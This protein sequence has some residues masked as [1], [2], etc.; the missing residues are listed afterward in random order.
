MSQLSWRINTTSS[1]HVLQQMS[2]HRGQFKSPSANDLRNTLCLYQRN[3]C[4]Y[5][6]QSIS[7]VP[8]DIHLVFSPSQRLNSRLAMEASRSFRNHSIS[9]TDC[10]RLGLFEMVQLANV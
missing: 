7:E 3:I 9:L 6:D 5:W 8:C 4:L 1:D 10:L 2:L